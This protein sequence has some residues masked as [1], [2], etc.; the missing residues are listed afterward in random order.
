ML[1]VSPLLVIAI[2]G[3]GFGPFAGIHRAGPV[4]ARNWK[5]LLVLLVLL[6]DAIPTGTMVE[7]RLRSPRKSALDHVFI[8]N[9][10]LDSVEGLLIKGLWK[11]ELS[12]SIF[13]SL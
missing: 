12:I 8:V 1:T 4:P 13:V 10:H 3:H 2:S 6:A 11:T 9:C 5:V 7:R